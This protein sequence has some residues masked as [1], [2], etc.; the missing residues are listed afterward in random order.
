MSRPYDREQELGCGDVMFATKHLFPLGRP[1]EKHLTDAT[2][3][4]IV[5]QGYVQSTSRQHA[6]GNPRV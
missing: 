6:K 4:V 1:S 5:C 2:E 3:L